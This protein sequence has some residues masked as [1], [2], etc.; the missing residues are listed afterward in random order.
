MRKFS[1]ISIFA[2]LILACS[3]DRLAVND[4][5]KTPVMEVAGQILYYEDI[6]E[7]M[8]SGLSSTDSSNFADNY[9][10]RWAVNALLYDKAANNVDMK[11]INRRVEQFKKELIINE[12]K[13]ALVE[14][15]MENISDDSIEIFYESRKD[16]FP[17][18]DAVVKGV[19]LKVPANAKNQKQLVT[20]L[21]DLSDENLDNIMRYCT[22]Y[23]LECKFFNDSWTYYSE[24]SPLLLQRLD[25]TDPQI[26][27]G[28]IVQTSEKENCYMRISGLIHA[29]KPMPLE[30]ATAEIRNILTNK[31]KHNII[32][33]FENELYKE[34]ENDNLIKTYNE[35]NR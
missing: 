19:F 12:Y 32:R 35:N 24:I 13:K 21:E 23:A 4:Y 22:Q 9:K 33:D 2:F 10:H 20:W 15:R 28:V 17:L 34:A 25:S 14:S 30:L 31:Q 29:G 26:T 6:M 27:R 5:G 11:N 3:C 7:I 8:P 1:A 16:I 18:D